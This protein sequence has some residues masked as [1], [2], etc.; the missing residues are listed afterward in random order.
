MI[1][2]NTLNY[3][4][5]LSKLEPKNKQQLISDLVKILDYVNQLQQVDTEKI[6][7]TIGGLFEFQPQP[8]R[9]REQKVE[10]KDKNFPD[11]Q[12]NYLRGP[13]IL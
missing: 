9:E 2:K 10:M 8:F 1:D 3:L 7:P 6:P 5:R 13:K 11:Q 4:A 12:N